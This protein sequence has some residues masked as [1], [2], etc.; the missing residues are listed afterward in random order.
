[1]AGGRKLKR[2]LKEEQR[3]GNDTR[4]LLD[5]MKKQRKGTSGLLEGQ[6]QRA[7]SAVKVEVKDEEDEA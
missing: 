6:E 1:V 7:G 3:K 5:D 2:E 4:K